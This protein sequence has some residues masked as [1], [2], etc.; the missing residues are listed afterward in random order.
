MTLSPA[1][2]GSRLA[3]SMPLQSV[4][5]TRLA[6]VV[7]GDLGT[8]QLY[9]ASFTPHHWTILQAESGPEALALAISRHPDVI[10]SETRLR[11]FDGFTLYELLHTDVG[12]SRIPFVFVTADA[13]ESNLSKAQ[14]SG[15][16]AVIA[17]PCLPSAILRAM[18]AVIARGRD[19]RRR[20]QA[21]TLKA[22]QQVATAQA[23]IERAGAQ[24]LTLK[25]AH[26]RGDTMA[27]PS[28]PPLLRCGSCDRTLLYVRSHIGGVSSKHPEQ[29]DYFACPFGCGDFEYRARTRKLR[30]VSA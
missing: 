28:P 4:E 26:L 25:K 21:L 18:A 12:T 7:D 24:R 29:W 2:A 15:A 1:H 13:T 11:G 20:S 17:K 10:L 22:E 27:P 30:K 6:L 3:G 16:D 23:L 8:R 5:T 9:T 19:V 14:Q